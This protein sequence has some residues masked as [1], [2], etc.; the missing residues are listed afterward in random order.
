M[1]KPTTYPLFL[2][3]FCSAGALAQENPPSAPLWDVGMFAVGVS[4]QAYPGAAE[5]INRGLVV[6]TVYYRGKYLR[7]DG[8]GAGIRAIKTPRFEFDIGF[9]AAFG[10]RADEVEI[11]SGMPELGTLIEFGPRAKW[12]LGSYTDGRLRAEFPLRGVFDV[13]DSFRR[14]GLAFE[15]KLIWERR[16]RDGWSYNA[17]I[18]ALIGDRKLNDTFYGVAPQFARA[19]RPAYVADSG[20]IA[21]R[22]AAGVSRAMGKDWR[23]FL[24]TRID[25]VHAAANKN[26]PLVQKKTGASVGFGLS[27]TIL[28]SKAQASD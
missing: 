4:Q 2:L 26:S 25:D 1:T 22:L 27:Y 6:P 12:N 23:L 19:D 9:A 11:R 20:L 5:R 21:V 24:F 28:R 16:V 18:A 14:K 10:S 8:D 15:P 13:T 17:S 3:A 7:A